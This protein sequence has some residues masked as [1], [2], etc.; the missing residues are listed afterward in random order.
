MFSTLFTST[1]RELAILAERTTHYTTLCGLSPLSQG[2]NQIMTHRFL[3]TL[4]LVACSV[5]P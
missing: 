4:L 1:S 3:G 5:S 2:A